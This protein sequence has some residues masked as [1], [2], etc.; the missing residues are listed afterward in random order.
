MSMKNLVMIISMLIILGFG[1]VNAVEA[2][3]E[4]ADYNFGCDDEI[5]QS[6]IMVGNMTCS[7]TEAAFASFSDDIVIDCNGY[8][9]D[10]ED[11]AISAILL[12]GNSNNTIKN[13]YIIGY[14][15]GVYLADSVGHTI[16]NNTFI[17]NGN[18]EEPDTGIYLDDCDSVNIINNTIQDDGGDGIHLYLSNFNILSGNIIM[19]NSEIGIYL[20]ESSNNTL[21]NN[22][23][24]ENG[25]CGVYFG[26]SPNNTLNNNTI[27]GNEDYGVYLGGS[28][29][30]ILINNIIYSNGNPEFEFEVGGIVLEDADNLIIE[31]N[32][33]YSNLEMG[34]IVIGSENNII[35]NNTMYDHFLNILLTSN[36]DSTENTTISNNYLFE[37][38]YNIAI[39]NSNTTNL[40]SNVIHNSG[41]GIFIIDVDS[42]NNTISSNIIN[43]CSEGGIG[44]FEGAGN[45]TFI[46]N[47][48]YDIVDF[49]YAV[50]FDSPGD[51]NIFN[52]TL[53]YNSTGYIQI[54]GEGSINTFNNLT[55]GY[56]SGGAG[57]INW[58]S[59][60]IDGVTNLTFDNL[61]LNEDFVS[62]N[63]SDEDAQEFNVTANITLSV[64]GCDSLEY[65]VK[66]TH[67]ANRSIILSDGI[68]FTTDYSTCAD[69]VST[70]SV[71]GF[72]AYSV[73]GEVEA[74][75]SSNGD[76]DDSSDADCRWDSDCSGDE[77]CNR[78]DECEELDCD[79]N[80]FIEDHECIEYECI[81]DLDC[82]D[83]E[84]CNSDDECEELDCDDCEYVDDHECIAY[85]CCSD[86]DCSDGEECNDHECEEVEPEDDGDDDSDDANNDDSDDANNDDSDDGSNDNSDGDSDD[87]GPGNNET[88]GDDPNS[89]TKEII[90]PIGDGS[91]EVLIYIESSD[92]D[93]DYV[94]VEV[95]GESRRVYSNNPQEMDLDNDG[96]NDIILIY[97]GDELSYEVL[98]TTNYADTNVATVSDESIVGEADQDDSDNLFWSVL[99]IVIGIILLTIGGTYIA[100]KKGLIGRRRGL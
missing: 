64:D 49:G 57:R 82:S 61:I 13:C 96:I 95:D 37:A 45:N 99:P 14:D 72:S 73:S 31:N 53:V 46:S 35:S 89:K 15:H 30:N 52:G 80:E 66:E 20:E 50:L 27:Y 44:I 59:L 92:T 43:N 93:G 54:V 63:S 83:N 5:N 70:F 67:S 28:P 97:D 79:S 77:F 51:N 36:D 75:S 17:A 91:E 48:I 10:G 81:F 24:Y 26:G 3:C 76:D 2:Y 55:L 65:Y 8:T 74:A 78:D 88:I 87:E 90:I 100:K 19:N 21:N 32:T 56:D 22:T 42:N 40:T 1:M 86:S 62:L 38:G 11:N 25:Y 12:G 71:T 29:Y 7:G 34:I 69:S 16:Y 33:I 94:D 58:N 85:D 68:T 18:V 4:G 9:L 47:I 6:C 39:E 84:V 60:I 23:I 41:F 98:G